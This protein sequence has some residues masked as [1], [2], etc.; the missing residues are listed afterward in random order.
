MAKKEF[1]SAAG[2]NIFDLV[3]QEYGTLEN[4][5]NIFVDNPTL[6]FND[7]IS[8]LTPL[9]VDSEGIGE[10]VIKTS[11]KRVNYVTNNADAYFASTEPFT[12]FTPNT[13][14]GLDIM[15]LMSGVTYALNK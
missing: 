4:I 12:G 1:K 13:T 8:A 2:Q 3:L 5:F 11:Y 9:E 7:N 14:G 6:G 10:E 15:V